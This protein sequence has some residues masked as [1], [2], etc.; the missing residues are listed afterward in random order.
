MLVLT[1]L[2][3]MMNM[4]GLS[5]YFQTLAVGIVIIVAVVLDRFRR[6]QRD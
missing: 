2:S 5:A 6:V 4:L 1:L 3:N